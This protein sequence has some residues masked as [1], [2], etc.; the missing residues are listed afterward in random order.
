MNNKMV[1]PVEGIEPP[2]LAE[3]DFESRASTS[4][5]TRAWGSYSVGPQVQ[6]RKTSRRL[7]P[8][9]RAFLAFWLPSQ[10]VLLATCAAFARQSGRSLK[11]AFAVSALPLDRPLPDVNGR[12]HQASS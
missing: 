10:R 8:D 5:A 3:R 1:V 4:S 6:P 11:P 12:K 2:L 7:G 9:L